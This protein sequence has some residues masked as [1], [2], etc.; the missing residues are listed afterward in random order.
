MGVDF[1]GLVAIATGAGGGSAGSEVV[2]RA[3]EMVPRHGSAQGGHEMQQAI[4][5]MRSTR[6]AG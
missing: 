1:T 6:S 2:D 5:Q 4:T 3:G